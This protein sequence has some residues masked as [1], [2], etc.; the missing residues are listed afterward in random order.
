MITLDR[1]EQYW[2]IYGNT[3]LFSQFALQAIE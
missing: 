2:R 1:A 3:R